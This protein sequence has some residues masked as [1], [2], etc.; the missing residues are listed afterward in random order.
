[1]KKLLVQVGT[2]PLQLVVQGA[3]RKGH[4]NGE[5]ALR[6]NIKGLIKHLRLERE[7][8]ALMKTRLEGIIAWYTAHCTCTM[9]SFDPNPLDYTSIPEEGQCAFCLTPLPPEG[10]PCEECGRGGG[11]TGTW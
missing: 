9:P 5:A 7:K 2:S 10:G 4:L 11:R 8:S 1:M 6:D 3:P